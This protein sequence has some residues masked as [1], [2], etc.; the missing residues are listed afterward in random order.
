[1]QLH[2]NVGHI[3]ILYSRI[4]RIQV[5]IRLRAQAAD[6]LTSC[7]VLGCK[8]TVVYLF[9]KYFMSKRPDMQ[10]TGENVYNQEMLR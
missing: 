1:M 10:G 3:C 4:T 9:F 2:T 8:G 6:E 5:S 7:R